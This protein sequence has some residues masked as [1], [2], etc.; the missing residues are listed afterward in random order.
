MTKAKFVTGSYGQKGGTYVQDKQKIIAKNERNICHPIAAFIVC[1]D[2]DLK[3][4]FNYLN[5]PSR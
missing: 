1:S 5:K 4:P 3:L 2:N